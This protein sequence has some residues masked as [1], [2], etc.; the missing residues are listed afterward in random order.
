MSLLKEIQHDLLDPNIRLS[1]ILKKA[2]VLAYQLGSDE[3]KEWTSNE[4]DGYEGGEADIPSYRILDTQTFGHFFGPFGKELRNAPIPTI[5]LPDE[6]SKYAT[7]YHF[8]HGIRELESLL[9]SGENS[10][11]YIWP[12]NNMLAISDK[13]W[14]GYVCMQAWWHVSAQNVEQILDT[15]RNRL[16]TFILELD[17]IDFDFSSE[18]TETIPPSDQVSQVFNN[19]I[20]GDHN[21]LGVGGK[22]TQTI[23]QVVKSGDLDSLR[24][25]LAKMGIPENELNSLVTAIE[26][27]G[28]VPSEESFGPKV[29]SWLGSAVQKVSSGLWKVGVEV[30]PVLIAKALTAYYG[31]G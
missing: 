31:W 18:D 12:P 16:L 10:F 11:R 5:G 8:S 17:E 13:V 4:M 23:T 1:D 26:D 29:K 20:L 2:K 22:V 25:Y 6:V 14:K 7:T 3:L 9:E 24:D 28:P 30:A 15:V 19:Y 27:D 21:I